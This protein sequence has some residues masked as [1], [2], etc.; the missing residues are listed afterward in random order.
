MRF[1]SFISALALLGTAAAQNVY[2]GAGCEVPGQYNCDS[3][4]YTAMVVCDNQY[5]WVWT[6]DCGPG[7]CAAGEA[8]V[9]NC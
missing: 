7:C 6:A 8:P 5:Q 3:D 9:C 4:T 2:I 1:F